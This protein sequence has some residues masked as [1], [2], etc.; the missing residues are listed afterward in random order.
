MFARHEK[1]TG[2]AEEKIRIAKWLNLKNTAHWHDETELVYCESGECDV[3]IEGEKIPLL[4]GECALV[5]SGKIHQ[6]HAR[7]GSVS[8]VLLIDSELLSPIVKTHRLKCS[9]LS[10]A[11][12]VPAF[13]AHVQAELKGKR[14]YRSIIINASALTLIAEIFRAEEKEKRSSSHANQRY[15]FLKDVLAEI[16]AEYRF[17]RFEDV[18]KKFGYSPSHFSRLFTSLTGMTFT[19]YLTAVRI[20]HA[21]ELL[22]SS[23]KRSVTEIA[24]YCGFSS[25]RNFNRYFKDFTGY[26]PRSLPAD[27]EFSQNTF[28]L[29]RDPF[30][31]T[32]KNSVL[33]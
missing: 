13:Y 4:K 24:G 23:D 19:K 26:T 10:H 9:K 6:I 27:Y 25:I 1:R 29:Y 2:T 30:D 31:P 18:C 12:D 33:L 14:E 8:I 11:P 15:A 5:E 32:E 3:E 28:R 21:V 17:L 20:G 22:Q 16:E 7:D